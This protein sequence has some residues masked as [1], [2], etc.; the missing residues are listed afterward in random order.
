MSNHKGGNYYFVSEVKRVDECFVDCLATVTTALAESGMVR[1]TFKESKNGAKI[2]VIEA[3]GEN[4][5][6][7]SENVIEARILTIYAGIK[8]DFLFECEYIPGDKTDQP[9]FIDV[10]MHFEF[11]KLGDQQLTVVNKSFQV[12]ITGK[13][14][15]AAGQ[16]PSG[17]IESNLLR[18]QVVDV[19]KVL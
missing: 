12:Q 11:N 13:Q 14:E 10:D 15:K 5:K 9:A 7:I 1:L 17:D 18:L 4:I 3:L 16:E 8:K 2:K 6:K 19:L